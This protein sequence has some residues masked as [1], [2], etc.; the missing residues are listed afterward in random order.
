MNIILILSLILI[1]LFIHTTESFVFTPETLAQMCYNDSDISDLSPFNEWTADELKNVVIVPTKSPSS[2]CFKANTIRRLTTNPYT[3]GPLPQYITNQT[4]VN[5][6]FFIPEDEM[7][8]ADYEEPVNVESVKANDNWKISF[9]SVIDAIHDSTYEF[10]GL[11]S[12]DSLVYKVGEFIAVVSREVY[13]RM[14][15]LYT[16]A[17]VAHAKAIANPN[18]QTLDEYNCKAHAAMNYIAGVESAY[19]I[20]DDVEYT[21]LT[22]EQLLNQSEEL[23]PIMLQSRLRI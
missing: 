8:E 5:Q 1:L 16:E 3:R 15:K 19:N 4:I 18:Y 17:R 12:F 14:K 10:P 11:G 2:H 22:L 20:F 6:P 13:E 9:A 7:N 23:K 21:D